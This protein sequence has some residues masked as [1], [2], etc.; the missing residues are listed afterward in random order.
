MKKFIYLFIVLLTV[1]FIACEKDKPEPVIEEPNPKEE[2]IGMY[3]CQEYFWYIS[4]EGGGGGD[5]QIR[6]E[7]IEVRQDPN[8]EDY[9]FFV[10]GYWDAT[11]NFERVYDGILYCKLSEHGGY[12]ASSNTTFERSGWYSS[13]A[14][15]PASEI[16][17]QMNKNNKL[18]VCFRYYDLRDA[19]TEEPLDYWIIVYYEGNRR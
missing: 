11:L 7:V 10:N 4:N 17:F 9:G 13:L 19:S 1:N 3:D 6:N 16:T 18:E 8:S 14:D 12:W 15:Y 2:I 5:P